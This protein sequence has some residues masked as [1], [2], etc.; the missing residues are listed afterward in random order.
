[1][2]MDLPKKKPEKKY[3][4]KKLEDAALLAFKKWEKQDNEFTRTKVFT[5]IK[6]LAYAMMMVSASFDRYNMDPAK[7]AYEYGV[8]L[9]QR[10]ILGEFLMRGY[11]T[12]RF[13]L[14]HYMRKNIKHVIYTLKDGDVWKEVTSD[15]EFL[16]DQS[17]LGEEEDTIVD[18]TPEPS[19]FL[20]RRVYAG[21][22]LDL[23]RMYYSM[24]EIRRLL[25]IATEHLYSNWYQY[26]S[27]GAPDD[28]RDFTIILVASAKRIVRIEN[29]FY[30]L[31]VKKSTLKRALSSAVRSTVFLST[32]VNTKFF[33][34]ELLLACD[35]D[36][37][38]RLVGILGGRTI[39]IPTTRELDTLIGGVVA[40]SKVI[41]EGKDPKKDTKRSVKQARNEYD[42]IFSS[43]ID[44]Q[45]F[46]SKAVENFNLFKN[47]S[48]SEPLI[49]MLVSS[50]NSL[51]RLFEKANFSTKDPTE[52]VKQYTELSNSFS[53]I[54]QSLLKIS[55]TLPEDK[56]I[57]SDVPPEPV[58]PQVLKAAQRAK[59]LPEKKL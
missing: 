50:I 26:V 6:D 8:Y 57:V 10:I 31:D 13:P 12:E 49:N 19:S 55:T 32:V 36:S 44:V 54:T 52:L 5:T 4:L 2:K 11:K 15:L 53:N 43:H 1:M 47:G 9:F 16:M 56:T 59:A 48:A 39:R 27:S 33:P 20:D 28:V 37:L 51:E 41:L 7:V 38:Y 35:M 25:P 30:G 14:Q 17:E 18:T 34:K 40:A 42:L 58:H 3:D 45:Y 23:L 46:V 24:E 21:K 22:L 29:V